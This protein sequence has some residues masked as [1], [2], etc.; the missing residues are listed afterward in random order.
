MM[1]YIIITGDKMYD[2]FIRDREVVLPDLVDGPLGAANHQSNWILV[3]QEV[4]VVL[5]HVSGT[6]LEGLK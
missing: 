1:Y 2:S 4:K 6:F 5:V 3:A